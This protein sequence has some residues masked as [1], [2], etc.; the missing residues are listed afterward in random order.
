MSTAATAP[1][2]VWTRTGDG[3]GNGIAVDVSG[4]VF[5]AGG[6]VA[7]KYD[8]SGNVARTTTDFVGATSYGVA[9]DVAGNIYLTGG[10]TESVT[11]KYDANMNVI[12]SR[13]EAGGPSYGIAIDGSG[14]VYVTG[15]GI[16]AIKYD[17][18]GNTLWNKSW[19]GGFGDTA[20]GISVDALGGVYVAGTS[21][22]NLNADFRTIKYDQSGNIT[23]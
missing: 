5:V 6:S 8:S 23:W 4:N 11:V 22:N 21:Y 13:T 14:N 12:W 17:S 1:A 3:I 2:L 7:I 18:G 16:G 10:V 19:Y 15:G 20:Y 9:V